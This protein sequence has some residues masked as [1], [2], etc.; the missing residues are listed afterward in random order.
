MWS[1]NG[2][3]VA[4]LAVAE[5]G[6]SLFVA[7]DAGVEDARLV[8]SGA[9]IYAAWSGD[10]KSL[11][12]HRGADLLLVD[13]DATDRLLSLEDNSS[14]YRTPAWSPIGD[15][16]AFVASEGTRRTLYV[17]PDSTGPVANLWAGC[18]GGRPSCGRLKA[19]DWP[20]VSPWTNPIR[21]SESSR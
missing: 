7:S 11:L 1:P 10:S 15:A 5:E 12:V 13:V 21:S 18:R 17:S 19:T 14:G 2:R 3:S 4:F 16:A 20:W 6:L 8:T 9:P